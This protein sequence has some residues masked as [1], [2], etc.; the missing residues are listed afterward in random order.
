MVKFVDIPEDILSIEKN[1][2]IENIHFFII[3]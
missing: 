1:N 3:I 2:H